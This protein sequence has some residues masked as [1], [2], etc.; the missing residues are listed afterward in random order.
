MSKTN[1]PGSR[2]LHLFLNPRR[3]N[4][5]FYVACGAS[6]GTYLTLKM[7]PTEKEEVVHLYVDGVPLKLLCPYSPGKPC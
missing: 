5:L 2:S 1:D 6:A 7:E 3:I 4:N